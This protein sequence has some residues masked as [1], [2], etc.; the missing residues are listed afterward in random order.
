MKRLPVDSKAAAPLRAATRSG[1]TLGSRYVVAV[2][3]VPVWLCGALACS[4]A[5]SLPLQ[6]P[7]GRIHSAPRAV[8]ARA[9]TPPAPRLTLAMPANR[10]APE[11]RAM[12]DL[13]DT[14]AEAIFFSTEDFLLRARGMQI[15]DD[16]VVCVRE[17][18]LGD[19]PLLV[20]GYS[21][22]RGSAKYNHELARQRAL[23][24]RRYLL[25]RGVAEERVSIAAGSESGVTGTG[26]ETWIFDRRVEISLLPG[27]GP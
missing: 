2:W 17:G 13:S 25:R 9:P 1:G 24:V 19:R 3:R 16:I 11:L 12:C 21:D 10:A 8:S 5:P 7:V 27:P 18:W 20:T 23:T 22:P 14:R 26:P 4:S 6:Q 15:L